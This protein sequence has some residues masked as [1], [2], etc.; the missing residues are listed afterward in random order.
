M[1]SEPKY[2]G[3]DFLWSDGNVLK[4]FLLF[5]QSDMTLNICPCRIFAAGAFFVFETLGT[6]LSQGRFST[7]NASETAE[8]RVKSSR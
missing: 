2:F 1:F 6:S 4:H 5:R 7:E 3:S 8:K